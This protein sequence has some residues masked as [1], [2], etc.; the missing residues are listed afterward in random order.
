MTG[1]V[2]SALGSMERAT[3]DQRGPLENS[4]QY[5]EAHARADIACSLRALREALRLIT[6]EGLRR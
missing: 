6:R 1:L 3:Q 5:L 4:I 2:E